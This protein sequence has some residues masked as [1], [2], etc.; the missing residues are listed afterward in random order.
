ML[1]T[2]E[3]LQWK[4]RKMKWYEMPKISQ[5]FIVEKRLRKEDEPLSTVNFSLVLETIIGNF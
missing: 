5:E 3:D 2:T 4:E 1:R